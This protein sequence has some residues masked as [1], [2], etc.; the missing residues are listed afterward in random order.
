MVP[1]RE[2]GSNRELACIRFVCVFGRPSTVHYVK[3]ETVAWRFRSMGNT[4]GSEL[5]CEFFLLL[6][7][8]TPF[9]PHSP[10]ASEKGRKNGAEARGWKCQL[11]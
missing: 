5:H 1:K 10:L 4:F 11:S 6:L 2:V 3:E 8:K 9:V 7:W